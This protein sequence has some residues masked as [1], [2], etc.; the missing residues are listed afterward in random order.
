M[1]FPI[2][3]NDPQRVEFVKSLSI[4]DT[5]PGENL[6]RVVKLCH[7]IFDV[8]IADISIL[9][10]DRE[11]FMSAVGLETAEEKREH[12]ICNFA[13]AGDD[14]F[15]VPNT[16]EHPEISKSHLVTNEPGIRYY[17]GAP[18]KYDN[19]NLGA[20]CLSDTKPRPPLDERG[21]EILNQLA[22]MVVREIRIQRV[23]RESL[24]LLAEQIRA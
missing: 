19:F 13:I 11:W 8:P 12:S 15:E 10:D 22:Q 5:S 20:L 23:L 17:I 6:T 18:L 14:L 1:K 21:R 3:E 24:A 7:S 16:L 4:L 2:S 9:A